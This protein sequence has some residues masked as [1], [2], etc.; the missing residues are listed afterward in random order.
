M[1]ILLGGQPHRA[2][3][4]GFVVHNQGEPKDSVETW[5]RSDGHSNAVTSGLRWNADIFRRGVVTA[6]ER[7][8]RFGYFVSDIY[9]LRP[10]GR[11]MP[12]REGG[13]LEPIGSDEYCESPRRG[14][15]Q[16]PLPRSEHRAL[17]WN[18]PV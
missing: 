17:E 1:P 14:D 7:R 2:D 15:A 8:R 4:T 10:V 12:G 11:V 9:T 6:R 13:D 3:L 18:S 5:N 16:G